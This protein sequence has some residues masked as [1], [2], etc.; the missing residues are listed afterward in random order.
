MNPDA[1]DASRSWSDQ[2]VG[3]AAM[4]G[5]GAGDFPKQEREEVGFLS[6]FFSCLLTASARSGRGRTKMGR[7]GPRLKHQEVHQRCGQQSWFVRG[8]GI[9]S[10]DLESWQVF[11][12]GPGQTD[13]LVR[14]EDDLESWSFCGFM[15]QKRR[16]LVE[17]SVVALRVLSPAIGRPPMSTPTAPPSSHFGFRRPLPVGSPWTEPLCRSLLPCIQQRLTASRLGPPWP[18]FPLSLTNHGPFQPSRTRESPRPAPPTWTDRRRG[19]AARH[20]QGRP[21]WIDWSPGPGLVR[22]PSPVRAPLRHAA[23]VTTVPIPPP[24]VSHT[25][26]GHPLLPWSPSFVVVFS[27]FHFSS[28]PLGGLFPPFRHLEVSLTNTHETIPSV[29]T[30][31]SRQLVA[32]FFSSFLSFQVDPRP[33][34]RL[35]R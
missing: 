9:W 1:R 11:L 22:G 33:R 23:V 19:N 5:R 24:V 29:V 14:I 4:Q 16:I 26:W 28:S 3:V 32:S 30:L 25:R 20:D 21:T 31:G 15:W 12:D 18:L 13:G 6:F 27:L 35:G 17:S 10:S 34:C 7:D 2:V 8:S